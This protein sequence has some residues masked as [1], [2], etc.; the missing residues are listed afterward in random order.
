MLQLPEK[1]IAFVSYI[2]DLFE[3]AQQ[4]IGSGQSSTVFAATSR[5]QQGKR[6]A[7]KLFDTLRH[8]SRQWKR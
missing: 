8:C 7:L 2:E 6:V 3:L 1:E 5:E 4:P